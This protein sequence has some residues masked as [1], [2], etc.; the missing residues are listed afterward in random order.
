MATT[1][2]IIPTYERA[3]LLEVALDSALAQTY[4]DFVVLIGDNSKTDACAALV[5]RY[6][7]PR[8]TYHRNRPG[9]G[10]QGNWLDLARRA[11]TPLLVSLHDD[12]E[13][14]PDFLAA[15]V[16]PMLDDPDLGVTFCDYWAIDA[17]GTRLLTFTEDESAR[18]RRN[19]L[20]EGRLRL[21]LA[22]RL[23]LVAVWNAVQPAYAAVLRREHV[24]TTDY[25]DDI[26][27]LYDIWLSYALAA[28]GVG[29]RYERRRLTNYRIHGTSITTGGF[30]RSEDAVFER[31]LSA[32]RPAA[33]HDPAL[34][35]VLDEIVEYWSQL[36]WA[37]ATRLMADGADG[38]AESQ[39][40]LRDAA[41]GLKGRR[42]AAAM[43][44]GRVT[45]VWKGL[46]VTRGLLHRARNE[47]DVRYDK[48]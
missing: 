38:R 8:I 30:A 23:R 35:A 7:D 21:D 39:A 14:H 32:H 28:R 46:Q 10:P 15:C 9:L 17:N 1:T 19:V 29:F 3:D 4:R 43:M 6:D 5:A 36:R 22:Q 11:S 18:T 42:R 34:A 24:V 2:V 33:D 20:P 44:A 40:E 37:R 47:P 41:Q 31:I 26:A 27:P 48:S 25:P 12:D 45:P 16:P 13:W